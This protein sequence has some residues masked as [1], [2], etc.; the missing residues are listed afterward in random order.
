MK[1]IIVYFSIV[2]VYACKSYSQV[3]ITNTVSAATKDYL[4]KSVFPGMYIKDI[5]GDFNAYLGNWKWTNGSDEIVFNIKKITQQYLPECSCYNYVISDGNINIPTAPY[6][7]YPGISNGILHNHY[8][9]LLS[10]FTVEDLA[11]IYDIVKNPYVIADELTFVL[12]TKAGTVYALTISDKNK[13]IAFGNKN[14]SSE[15][16]KQ[17]LIGDLIKNYDVLETNSN[18]TNE[19]GFQK[20]MKDYQIGI[21]LF[22][23]S[24]SNFDTWIKIQKTKNNY[25]EINCN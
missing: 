19:K 16:Q 21:N 14:L 2:I 3:P 24:I 18:D 13:L 8:S 9:G 4:S 20:M 15:Y 5:N 23:G 25:E 7:F 6:L 1:K 22:R 10:I 12:V 11:G 17:Y